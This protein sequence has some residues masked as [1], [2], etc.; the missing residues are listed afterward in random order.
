MVTTEKSTKSSDA[1]ARLDA[2]IRGITTDEQFTAYLTM[3][4]RFH[5]YSF[6]NV[7]MILSQREDATHVAGFRSW[8]AMGRCVR[9]GEKG[10]AILVP[11]RAKIDDEATGE[12][13]S[14]VRGFGVGYVFDVSQTDGD[15][16]PA[17]P[18]PIAIT[19]ADPLAITVVDRISHHLSTLGVTL[20]YEEMAQNG[21]WQPG[22][23][24]IALNTALAP[25]MRAKT[26]CHELAHCLSAHTGGDDRQRAE[27]V[28]EAAAF[29]ALAHV[30]IDSEGYSA[31]YIAGW[32]R[33]ID[34]FRVAL[35]EIEDVSR[36]IV[37]IIRDSD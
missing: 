2:A 5:A 21:Y 34:A 23:R 37:S 18:M 36:Q 7:M 13:V 28:A 10:I 3:Q 33:D 24:K 1:I 29:V 25:T 30:G 20:A 27:V 16:L 22:E 19:A 17:P 32:G 15:E 8:L 14:I 12:R 9:K 35:R 11:H 6:N 26:L 31:P 4:A